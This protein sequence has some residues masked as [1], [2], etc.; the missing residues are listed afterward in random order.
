VTCHRRLASASRN[1]AAQPEC[2]RRITARAFDERADTSEGARVVETDA[3][4]AR[5]S[6]RLSHF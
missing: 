6:G 3:E 1:G 2:G 5:P 4:P